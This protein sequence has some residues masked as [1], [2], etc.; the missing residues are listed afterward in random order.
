MIITAKKICDEKEVIKLLAL[1]RRGQEQLLGIQ[2]DFSL[3][4]IER[5]LYTQDPL[6]PR[7][8]TFPT[9][10]AEDRSVVL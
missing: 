2:R 1:Y 7:I 5:H 10:W 6:P 8:D 4:E 9:Q 3:F